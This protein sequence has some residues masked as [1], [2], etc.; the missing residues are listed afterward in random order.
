MDEG[1]FAALDGVG[2]EERC[3]MAPDEAF[4]PLLHRNLEP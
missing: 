3:W 2:W 1:G 4:E